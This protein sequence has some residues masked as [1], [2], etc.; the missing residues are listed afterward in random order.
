MA[1][2]HYFAPSEDGDDAFSVDVSAITFGSGVLA[3]I[4]ESVDAIRVDY[5]LLLRIV[6]WYFT[7]AF[8]I[9]YVLR[10]LARIARL[11]VSASPMK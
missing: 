5:G 1:C 9:E 7:I 2:C 10:R 8:S 4:L 3:V 6:E 11:S